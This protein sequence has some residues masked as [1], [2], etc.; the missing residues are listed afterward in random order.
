LR[1]VAFR[2]RLKCLCIHYLVLF[3]LC[4]FY[5]RQRL[6]PEVVFESKVWER[7]T[8]CMLEAYCNCPC[9]ARCTMIINRL[10]EAI[11]NNS[12]LLQVCCRSVA[13]LLQVC[14]SSVAAL[15]QLLHVLRQHSC[16]TVCLGCFDPT[17]TEIKVH[18]RSALR[19]NSSCKPLCMWSCNC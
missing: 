12:G 13:G 8:C 18:Q 7:K 4:F 5:S 17:A 14:C 10:C 3:L 19:Q 1:G 9:Y 15:L 16:K 11:A 2:L 6:K